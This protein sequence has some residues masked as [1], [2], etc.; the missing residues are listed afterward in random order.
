[1]IFPAN[2]LLAQTTMPATTQSTTSPSGGA[3]PTAFWQ[4]PLFFP[5]ILI[6]VFLLFSSRNRKKADQKVQDMLGNLKKGDRVQTIG[7]ILGTV[8]EARDNEVVLKVDE[9]NNTKMRFSRKAIHIV[10]QDDTEK[11]TS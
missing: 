9:T 3:S 5:I 2:A 8:V 7:G 4:S 6:G 11:K 10:L 1:L